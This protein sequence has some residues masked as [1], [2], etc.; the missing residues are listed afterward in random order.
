MRKL[1]LSVLKVRNSFR[2]DLCLRW[3]RTILAERYVIIGILLATLF[4]IMVFP[5]FLQIKQ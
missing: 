1:A 5:V 3:R 4:Y 2:A